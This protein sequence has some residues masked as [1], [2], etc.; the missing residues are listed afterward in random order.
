MWPGRRYWIWSLGVWLVLTFALVAYIEWGPLFGRGPIYETAYYAWF[1]FWAPLFVIVALVVGLAV[2]AGRGA[3]RTGSGWRWFF[4]WILFGLATA[5]AAVEFG[6]AMLLPALAL[7]AWLVHRHGMRRSVYGLTAG[8]GSL[9]MLSMVLENA[10]T[11][12]A[13]QAVN[14]PNTDWCSSHAWFV[15]SFGFGVLLLICGVVAQLRGRTAY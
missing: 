13:C 4:V 14:G 10:R 11:T 8:L 5:V 12:H 3:V 7:A 15:P 2:N 9:L 6:P 1:V